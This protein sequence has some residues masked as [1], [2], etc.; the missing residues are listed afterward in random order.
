MTNNSTE[1]EGLISNSKVEHLLEYLL[2]DAPLSEEQ[3]QHLTEEANTW[4]QDLL[5]QSSI[6]AQTRQLQ[7]Y[8]A[9][10]FTE[11]KARWIILNARIQDC[12]RQLVQPDPELLYQS[13]ILSGFLGMLEEGLEAGRL[14][15]INDALANQASSL[16]GGPYVVIEGDQVIIEGKRKV[17]IYRKSSLDDAS[18]KQSS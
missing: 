5:D 16:E 12:N 18:N 15:L 2:S 14:H 11:L 9:L 1:M 6:F 13:S 10:R 8:I 4:K 7:S 3:K 17:M